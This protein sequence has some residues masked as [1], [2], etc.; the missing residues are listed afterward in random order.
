MSSLVPRFNA[1]LLVQ[2]LLVACCGSLFAGI[3]GI[4]H[5]QVT[6]TLA[7]EYFT[8]F[9]FTQFSY[10]NF[11]LSDRLFVAIIGVLATWW[12]GFVAAW[13]LARVVLIRIPLPRA[14]A[15]LAKGFAL[16]LVFALLGGLIGA[17][18]PHLKTVNLQQWEPW[19][20]RLAVHDA[21]AFVRV[22]YIHNGSYLGAFIGLTIALVYCW[23][24]SLRP[25]GRPPEIQG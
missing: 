12:V 16:V 7:P 6:Y 9:K 15:L 21:A 8:R 1:K 4:L 5:D 20:E 19:M 23:R 3:Y 14:W 17:L 11:G 18:L 10:A 2:I 24:S 13:F 25:T 22:S